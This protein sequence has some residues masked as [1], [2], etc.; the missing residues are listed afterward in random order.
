MAAIA[1]YK[2]PE[3]LAKMNFF[4]DGNVIEECS[5]VVQD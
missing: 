1:S 4:E 2:I 5:V 3:I